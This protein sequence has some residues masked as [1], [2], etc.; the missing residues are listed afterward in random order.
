MKKKKTTTQISQRLVFLEICLLAH[1]KS[2]VSFIQ[3]LIFIE[4]ITTAVDNLC[5]DITRK[6][7]GKYF[8]CHC[9]QA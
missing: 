7:E 6:G 2:K 1:R 4:W 8:A 5:L 9:I 3:I